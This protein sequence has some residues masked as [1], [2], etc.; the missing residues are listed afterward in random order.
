MTVYRVPVFAMCSIN[1]FVRVTAKT[2]EEA[3]THAKKNIRTLDP[4]DDPKIDWDSVMYWEVCDWED[5]LME[6]EE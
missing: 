4:E 3:I 1:G 6:E 2:P 5:E